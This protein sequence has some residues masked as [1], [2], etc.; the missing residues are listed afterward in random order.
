MNEPKDTK[1]ERTSIIDGALSDCHPLQTRSDIQEHTHYSSVSGTTEA[2]LLVTLHP[3][4][5][6]SL[7]EWIY[8]E[9]I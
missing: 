2:S 8:A 9:T 1:L 6:L 4:I 7:T 3:N 5:R